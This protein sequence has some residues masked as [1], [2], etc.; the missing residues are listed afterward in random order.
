MVDRIRKVV[1]NECY[2]GPITLFFGAKRAFF[3]RRTQYGKSK[4]ALHSGARLV[5][6]ANLCVTLADSIS[7][8][9]PIFLQY[10][11]NP[12]SIPSY[13]FLDPEFHSR[14]A[15]FTLVRF[16]HFSPGKSLEGLNH[17]APNLF[18]AKWGRA[19]LSS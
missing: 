15:F 2:L 13:P 17:D 4:E 9:N 12:S 7:L 8:P 1:E 16:L 11:L 14:P 6:Q 18:I 3:G 5:K 19:K 10:I